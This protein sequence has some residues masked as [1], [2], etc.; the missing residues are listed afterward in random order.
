MYVL[1]EWHDF[2][3]VVIFFISLYC[4]ITLFR[5]WRRDHKDWN[6][7]TTDYWYALLMWSLAGCVLSAQGVTLDRPLTP[8]TVFLAAAIVVTG[9]GLHQKGDW[10]SAAK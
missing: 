8:G 3:R 5:R 2:L 1:D 4:I 10:G 6:T 9:K 7:K